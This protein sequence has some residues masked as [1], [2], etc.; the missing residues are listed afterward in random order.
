M[1]IGWNPVFENAHKT[2]EAYLVHEFEDNFYG[3]HLKVEVDG[4]LRAESIF[5]DF[6]GL[7]QA[8]QCDILSVVEANDKQVVK[9]ECQ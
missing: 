5:A 6:D 1:S 9:T 2:I 4:Y 7:I 3:E 8:I